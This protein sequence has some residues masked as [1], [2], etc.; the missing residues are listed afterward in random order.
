[1]A[2]REVLK[3]ENAE[4]PSR[5]FAKQCRRYL[6]DWQL[7]GMTF[8]CEIQLGRK[9]VRHGKGSGFTFYRYSIPFMYF[10]GMSRGA[11]V[12]HLQLR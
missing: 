12:K 10:S 9:D 1:M 7:A 5:Y 2:K 4:K 6:G 8:V 11:D 3:V